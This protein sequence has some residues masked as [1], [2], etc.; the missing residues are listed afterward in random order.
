MDTL[1]CSKGACEVSL[2]ASASPSVEWVRLRMCGAQG[3]YR[4]P[5]SSQ[6]LRSAPPPPCKATPLIHP[7]HPLALPWRRAY[8]GGRPRGVRAASWRLPG[9]GGLAAERAGWALGGGRS[10]GFLLLRPGECWPAGRPKGRTGEGPRPGRT[11]AG[12]RRGGSLARSSQ[13]R[14]PRPGL[15]PLG[16]RRGVPRRFCFAGTH[17]ECPGRSPV[18]RTQPQGAPEPPADTLHCAAARF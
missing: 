5:T 4:P 14:P 1:S 6:V 16:V 17:A 2:C 10:A 8:T 13:I 3:R 15:G 7:A 12:G 11:Q 9:P 18:S